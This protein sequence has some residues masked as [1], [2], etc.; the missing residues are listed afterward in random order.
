MTKF[1]NFILIVLIFTSCKKEENI[2]LEVNV[3]NDVIEYLIEDHYF[4]ESYKDYL[5]RTNLNDTL[6]FDNL[7]ASYINNKIERK[8]LN[9]YIDDKLHSMDDFNKKSPIINLESID[10]FDIYT[11]TKKPR[12]NFSPIQEIKLPEKLKFSSFESSD[13]F[14][15]FSRVYFNFELN[16]AFFVFDMSCFEE[17]CHSISL[18]F[19][20]IKNNK[21]EIVKITPLLVS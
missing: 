3:L 1:L 7:Y 12:Q 19:V 9:I 17:Y 2:N 20:E 11:N 8:T 15:G 5:N 16:K 6:D 4:Y 13:Y 18:I 10:D 21:W 14:I